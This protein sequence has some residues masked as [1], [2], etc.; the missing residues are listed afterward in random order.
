MCGEGCI[1]KTLDKEL[2]NFLMEV[3]KKNEKGN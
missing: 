3:L 2:T 1:Q